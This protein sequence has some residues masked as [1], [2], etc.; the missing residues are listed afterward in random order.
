MGDVNQAPRTKGLGAP[1][2][3][4]PMLTSTN[5]TVW[6]MRMKITLRVS[7]VWETINPGSAD[8][9][10][11][12]MAITLLFQTIPK[13]LILQIG[14]QDSAKKLWDAIKSRH[15]GADRVK[16][17]RL[18]T[19][20]A[21]LDRLKMGEE[22]VGEETLSEDQGKL[23]FSNSRN[24]PGGFGKFRGGNRSG[25]NRG[26]FNRGG[27]N[28]GG[29]NR[30]GFNRE[31]FG[32]GRGRGR[33]NGQNQ[34]YET[35]EH[36]QK[37]KK[38]LSKVICW[39]CDKPGHYAS[40][41][42]ERVM[43]KKFHETQEVKALYVHEVVLLNEDKVFPNNYDTNNECVWYLDNGGINHMTRNKDF[44]SSLD[45]TI[46]GK[47]KFGNGSYVNIV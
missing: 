12:D 35:I 17:E 33:F 14:E 6:A 24:Y 39:R 28:I 22:R 23:M 31:S 15:Q 5:Y 10:K 20:M 32:R 38:D 37:E 30:G 43:E 47:V 34:G 44:F 25:L 42:S 18:Q 36:D 26:S 13:M 27:Y 8:P 46:K 9:K 19:L 4:C 41:C 1:S 2:I 45:E 40:V 16:E 7:K 21:E 11:N 3:H 29:Y